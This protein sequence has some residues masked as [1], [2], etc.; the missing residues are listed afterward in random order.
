[1]KFP[2]Q[3]NFNNNS[4]SSFN[5]FGFFITLLVV[6]FLANIGLSEINVSEGDFLFETIDVLKTVSNAGF[7]FSL[8]ALLIG[9]IYTI[10]T[11]EN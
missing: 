4:N 3:I 8:F 6:C 2:I 11:K 7:G 9:F 1:M 10:F 5:Y